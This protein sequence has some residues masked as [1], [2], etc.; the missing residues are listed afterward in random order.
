MSAI[1]LDGSGNSG[2][3]FSGRGPAPRWSGTDRLGPSRATAGADAGAAGS[4]T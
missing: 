3:V 4:S 2:S 1:E